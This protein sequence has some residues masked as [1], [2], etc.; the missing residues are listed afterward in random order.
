M[1]HPFHPFT[2]EH[3]LALGIGIAVT[4]AFLL[5]GS[6][7]GQSERLARSLLAFICLSVFGFSQI[8]WLLVD[9]PMTIDNIVP[10]HMCDIA[11]ITAG[12][13][14]I[15]RRPLLCAVTYFWGIAATAQ[16][17]L[18]PALTVGFPSPLFFMFFVHHFAV[19]IAALYLPVVCGW[20]PQRPLWLDPLRVFGISI[21]YLLVVLVF[22]HFT[23]SNFAFVSHP[24]SN[25]SLIDHLGPWPWYIFSL[26]GIAILLYSLLVLP[27]ARRS[28]AGV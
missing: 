10:L 2:Q 19:V 13:A 23:G 20:R 25:P 17:L 24:P 14:L 5:A 18:T 1:T 8:A 27:F 16:A 3:F 21:I 4:A 6:R 9:V 26:L 28:K 7:G 11:A 15:T 12:F 22:N